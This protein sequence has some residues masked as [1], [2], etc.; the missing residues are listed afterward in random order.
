MTRL[1]KPI[2]LT[3]KQRIALHQIA[4]SRTHR[5]DHIDRANIILLCADPKNHN[6]LIA[7]KLNVHSATVRKWRK[8]WQKNEN[9]LKAFDLKEIGIVYTRKLLEIL[10][11]EQRSGHPCKFTAEEVCKIISLSCELPADSD[12]PLS[13]WSLDALVIEVKKRGIVE[14][15][16]RSRLA[17]F[18]KSGRHNVAQ[19]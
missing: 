3:D 19:S 17:V 18:L 15:I 4:V 1:S 10:S 2:T 14:N 6:N 12:L 7:K 13:H 11:D 16:S 9:K 8:K 5:Q